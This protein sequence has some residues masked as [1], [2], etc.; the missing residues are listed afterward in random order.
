[1]S[2]AE[3]RSE[4]E[5]AEAAAGRPPGTTTL[6]AVAKLQPVERVRQVLE[7]GH[8]DFGE[9]RIHEAQRKW[10]NLRN[11]F[12]DV[13]LHLLGPLQSNKVGAAMELFDVVHS[14]D[15][16]RIA[17]KI[18]R[19]ADASGRCPGLLVQVNTGEER[20]K[21]GVQPSQLDAFL[22]E[23]K[24]LDLPITGLMC[25]PPMNDEA[26]LHFGLLAALAERHGLSDLSMGMS[27]DFASAVRLGATFVRVGTAVFGKRDYSLR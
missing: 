14:L 11:E 3:I 8:R 20:Q 18:A 5:T 6:V 21:S 12:P 23:L 1:M 10:P 24:P 22:D 4:I 13:R 16:V 2:L 26:A 19:L 27:A 15:R 9:N 25:I 17:R 7:Q